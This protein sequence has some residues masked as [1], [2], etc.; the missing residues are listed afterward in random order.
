MRKRKEGL[1]L[2]EK[3]E[4]ELEKVKKKKVVSHMTDTFFERVEENG[5]MYYQRRSNLQRDDTLRTNNIVDEIE[6]Q[7]RLARVKAEEEAKRDIDFDEFKEKYADH[8]EGTAAM[9]R[10]AHESADEEIAEVAKSAAKKSKRGTEMN[11][12]NS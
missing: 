6:E 5:I 9:D 2:I 8:I 4:K 7:E 1:A 11:K 10:S 3:I 12:T